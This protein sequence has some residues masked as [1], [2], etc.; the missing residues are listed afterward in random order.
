MRVS[1]LVLLFVGLLLITANKAVS[2]AQPSNQKQQAGA[3]PT[4]TPEN[5]LS[6]PPESPWS[7]FD[8]P[9]KSPSAVYGSMFENEDV[10]R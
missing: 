5:A 6:E 8:D 1:L 7:A 9:S 10:L 2:V 3:K 4:T